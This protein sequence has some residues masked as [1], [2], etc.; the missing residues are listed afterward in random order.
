MGNPMTATPD[1]LLD[2]VCGMVVRVD[3][4]RGAGLI[5]E[6]AD[7][8]YAFCSVRCV[9]E[10]SADPSGW[11]A[12]DTRDTGGPAPQIDAGLRRWYDACRCCMHDAYPEIVAALD[13][14]RRAAAV[15]VAGAGICEVAE[16]LPPAP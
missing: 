7:R 13:A 6:H 14:E 9:R 15:P 3:Q 1:Q 16:A 5:I 4:A 11:A 8:V 12:R 10:F 2:P